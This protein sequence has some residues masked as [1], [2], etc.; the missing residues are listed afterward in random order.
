MASGI[1]NLV[2]SNDYFFFLQSHKGGSGKESVCVPMCV[3]A[4]TLVY[5]LDFLCGRVKRALHLESDLGSNPSPYFLCDLEQ[6]T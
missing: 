1:P 3:Y 4:H 5:I 6:V 2:D